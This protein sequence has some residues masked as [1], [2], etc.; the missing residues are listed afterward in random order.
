MGGVRVDALATC[1]ARQPAAPSAAVPSAT[2]TPLASTRGRAAARRGAL[3]TREGGGS[4][5]CRR[6]LCRPSVSSPRP[7]YALLP[8]PSAQSHRR[9]ALSSSPPHAAAAAAGAGAS[10]RAT[11][12]PPPCAAQKPPYN[13]SEQ[14]YNNYC[15]SVREYLS[16][17]VLPRIRAKVTRHGSCVTIAS[18]LPSLSRR[19]LGGRA[20]VRQ[21]PEGGGTS[22]VVASLSSHHALGARVP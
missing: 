6:R 20:R 9:A 11:P 12:S 22:R 17:R 8:N 1:Q 21:W 3:R 19:A 10:P 18:P 7:S 2:A 13:W 15:S 14:L 5:A 16:S 4:S